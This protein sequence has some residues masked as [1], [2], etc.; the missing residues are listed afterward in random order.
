LDVNLN[1]ILLASLSIPAV[2]FIFALIVTNT[3]NERYAIAAS[4]GFAML[5]AW[6]VSNVKRSAVIACFLLAASSLLIA[7]APRRIASL[8]AVADS[9]L[10][11][12][13]V[14]LTAP[15]AQ[16]NPDRTNEDLVNHWHEFRPDLKITSPEAFVAAHRRFYVLHSDQSTDVITPWLMRTFR[17]R[18]LWNIDEDHRNVWFFEATS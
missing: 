13:L 15:T 6:F 16:V 1:S 10:K 2:V 7:A 14:Y 12:R 18:A 8:Q 11:N 5:F 4:F 17:L 3:F 9:G